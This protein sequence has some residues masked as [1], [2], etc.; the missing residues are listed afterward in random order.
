MLTLIRPISLRRIRE[1]RLRAAMTAVGIALGVAVL[2]AV[3]TV[4]RG[5]VGSFAN[6]LDE[7][8]GRVQL[9]VRGADTGLD[10]A[11]L[12]SIRAVP[13]VRYATPAIQRTLNVADGEGDAV[14]ILGLNFTEDPAVLQH[15]Y[16]LDADELQRKQKANA[17]P[18]EDF[19][20]DPFAML[21][22][23]RQLVVTHAFAERWHK[24]KD[25]TIDLI[26][27]E[28]RQPFTLYSVVDAKG[29]LKAMGG[30]L[31]VMDY[32]D[33]Q[34]VFDLKGR[35]DRFD[36]AVADAERPGQVEAVAEALRKATGG[37]FQVERPGKRQE[38]QNTM[39]RT[40]K[41]GLTMGAGI[42]LIVGMF[43]I[44]HTLSIS[45]VQRRTE[46]GILRAGGATR[47]QI[48]ALFTLEGV[49]F[50]VLGS[51]LGLGLGA[52][53]A[54]GM[55]GESARSVSE[56]YMRV[57]HVDGQVPGWALLLGL[58]AGTLCSALAALVP[59]WRA[60]RLSPI[61]TIR[62]VAWSEGEATSLRF[63][64]REWAAIGV[65]AAVPLVAQG[66]AVMGFPLS[67]L[68][69]MA[70]VLLGAT[71]AG[72]WLVTAS[73]RVLGPLCARLFAVEGRLAA[74]NVTRNAA[75]SAVTVASLMVGLSMVMGS[76]ILVHSFR[77]SIDTWLQQTVPADLFVTAGSKTAGIKNATV[78]PK[79]AAEIA[80]VPGID[81]VDMVR[82]RN[83]DYGHSR[84][85]LLSL[86]ARIRFSRHSD[87]P[88]AR[89]QGAR[90]EVL[91]ALTA[92]KGCIVSETFAH[93]FGHQPGDEI[94]LHTA[95]GRQRFRILATI[96]DYSSDQGAI[97][98]DRDLYIRHWH[99]DKVDTFE[100]YLK[101]G[102]DPE[103]VR[104]EILRRW[105]AKY[106][107]FALT[108]RQLR[109]EIS[110][111]VERVFE[112]TRV[113]ELVTMAIAILSVV[114][115]LLTSILDRMREIGVLRAIGMLRGQ[116]ARMVVIESTALA[117]VAALVGLGVGAVNG[118]LI[119]H[120]VQAQEAGWDMPMA[121]PW[122]SA[123]VYAVVV[124]AV[125]GLAAVYP[126]RVAGRLQVK[127]A[128]GYE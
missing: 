91:P 122:A 104:R 40:F 84:V 50:G 72:R 29:P 33:A 3:V 47:R 86:Q 114:N 13:G 41:L 42:A 123:A 34:E 116:L 30:N 17:G 21:D 55:M 83:I 63:R 113:L 31:A 39:L 76:A 66:P 103:T 7:I 81:A 109:E 124:V 119:L 97:F 117:V 14:V 57:D 102:A 120:V 118:W 88:L 22:A 8:S 28:G 54:R 74:D 98:F 49:V 35:V 115:T 27:R 61:E 2:V 1:H 80:T 77:R 53:L 121:F 18:Q 112:L 85:V 93:R 44:Y 106:K 94:E 60:S 101:A 20:A 75:K 70:L 24:R 95:D 25:E 11:L 19:D 92:G 99:D 67:G 16:R 62:T 37:R 65:W 126:A 9:E 4:N 107:L 56:I 48:V 51:L 45:V 90:A 105:G 36:V 128:L 32:L 43:L 46:I 23:Q 69:A 26:T 73:N 68:A 6:S 52:L 12:A 10:E 58:G 100:P 79:L 87:W 111:I 127:E 125:G 59:A 96:T 38:R 64:A 108:N 110:R 71:M 5:I 89:W 78:D 82:I 15:F